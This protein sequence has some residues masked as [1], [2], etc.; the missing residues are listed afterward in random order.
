MCTQAKEKV[1]SNS[2][3]EKPQIMTT[4]IFEENAIGVD[5]IGGPYLLRVVDEIKKLQIK[6]QKP[7]SPHTF[8]CDLCLTSCHFIH[9]FTHFLHCCYLYH[10]R[11]ILKCTCETKWKDTKLLNMLH[12]TS[13]QEIDDFCNNLPPNKFLHNAGKW[14]FEGTSFQMVKFGDISSFDQ[15]H[16]KSKLQSRKF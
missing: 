11:W 2:I 13:I 1:V 7:N 16:R 3:F 15:Q 5:L 6:S 14:R 4:Y 9:Q 12:Q 8:G 10:S